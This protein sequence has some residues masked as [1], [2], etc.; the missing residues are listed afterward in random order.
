MNKARLTEI[1]YILIAAGTE[2]GYITLNRADVE[3]LKLLDCKEK[4]DFVKVA[5]RMQGYMHA[6][7]KPPEDEI[8]TRLAVEPIQLNDENGDEA[9][10]RSYNV[11]IGVA[12]KACEK[13]LGGP[14]KRI[15]GLRQR[16]VPAPL[17]EKEPETAG[18]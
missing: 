15:P 3:H 14:L 18:V 2:D 9:D 5:A 7:M 6:D 16:D 12:V 11:N 1:G 10:I 4:V 13:L 8:V 17:P